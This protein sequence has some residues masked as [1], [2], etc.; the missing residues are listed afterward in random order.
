MSFFLEPYSDLRD[1]VK[2]LVDLPKHVTK[3][4]E[5]ILQVLIH[6]I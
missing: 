6:L 4:N 3:K 5:I 2:V 1:Q